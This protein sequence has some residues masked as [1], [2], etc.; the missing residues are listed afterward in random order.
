MRLFALLGATMLDGFAGTGDLAK[1]ALQTWGTSFVDGSSDDWF[2]A[3]TLVLWHCNP[4]ATRIPDAHFATEARYRGDERRHR[5]PRYSPARYP[6]VTMGESAPGNGRG[7]GVGLG[8][9]AARAQCRRRG[10][11]TRADRS[12]VSGA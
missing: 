4:I 10:I 12:A 8:A 6:C 2:R 7:A 3:D 9:R 5:Q 11:R 1:G